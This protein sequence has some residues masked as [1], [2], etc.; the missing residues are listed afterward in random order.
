VESSDSRDGAS[1]NRV[2]LAVAE[3]AC[4]LQQRESRLS[5]RVD[6]GEAQTAATVSSSEPL[7]PAARTQ[8]ASTRPSRVR[9][10]AR[11]TRTSRTR[12]WG[13]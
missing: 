2:D 13:A 11:A 3:R 9:I 10:V 6:C 12:R 8:A 1:K 4:S 5:A 7:G